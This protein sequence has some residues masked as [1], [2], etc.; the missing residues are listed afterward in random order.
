MKKIVARTSNRAFVG[1]PVCAL[2]IYYVTDSPSS[3]LT[4]APNPGRN[5]DYLN[6]MIKFTASI[7]AD[8]ARMALLSESLR[9]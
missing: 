2:T 7:V 3:N 5:D 9:G 1:L 8:R 4:D 6:L